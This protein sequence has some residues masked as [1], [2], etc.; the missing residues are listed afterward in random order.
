VRKVVTEKNKSISAVYT[1]RAPGPSGDQILYG[2]DQGLWDFSKEFAL[3][4][5]SDTCN[6]E[7]TAELSEYM[8]T[9]VLLIAYSF[10]T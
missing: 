2:G 10:S 9:S 7:V 1:F 6:F 4:R 5:S 8:R 3:Y